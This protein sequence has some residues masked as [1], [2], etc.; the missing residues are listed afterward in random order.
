MQAIFKNKK[1]DIF[2]KKT[3]Y[4][5]DFHVLWQFP[6]EFKRNWIKQLDTRFMII[7]VITFI[8]EVC[9][10]LSL[11][12][13]VK[14]KDKGIDAN[15]IQK[16]YAHLLL[17]K[18]GESD[19]SYANTG[20]Q[21]TYLYG[22]A[23]ENK[24][25]TSSSENQTTFG[26][27]SK[28]EYLNGS[29]KNSGGVGSASNDIAESYAGQ[30]AIHTSSNS[31]ASGS[32]KNITSLGLLQYLSDDNNSV[33]GEDLGEIFAQGD[34]NIQYLESSLAHVQLTNSDN[35][36]KSPSSATGTEGATYFDK[37]KGS[38][39]N[40]SIAEMRSSVSPLE[41]ANYVT[42]AKNTELEEFSASALNKS[43]SKASARNADHVTRV[44]L[45]HNR[46]IQDCYKQALKKN[47]DVKGKVVIR[48]S[49]TPEGHVDLVNVIKTTV[50]YEPLLKCIVNRIG[51]W[52]DFGESDP[53]LGTVS[54]RQ[55]YV[56]GY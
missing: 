55:T 24:Q 39:S 15:S 49:V 6:K 7:L 21:G 1:V 14:G 30:T 38:K 29:G 42:V 11:L 16:R 36:G 17:K 2:L 40:V 56:F 28:N 26:Q 48:F 45:A 41:T 46:A 37:I 4:S 31:Y 44:V 9:I 5:Q 13:W 25:S 43:G 35:Q 3:T 22:I 33:S 10:I 34:R 54:Y 18:F 52:N 53:S 23:E 12:S 47:P 27:N 8:F 32:T 19:F 51:R 50:D 20:P